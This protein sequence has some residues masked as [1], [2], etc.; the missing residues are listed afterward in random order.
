MLVQ[1]KKRTII[2]TYTYGNQDNDFEKHYAEMKAK[3][4]ELLG[5]NL[6]EAT[7]SKEEK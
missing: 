5:Y 2:E 1:L 6:E 3:G 4:W 7:Y